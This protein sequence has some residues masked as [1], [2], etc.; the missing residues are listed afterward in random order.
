MHHAPSPLASTLSPEGYAPP[1]ASIWSHRCYHDPDDRHGTAKAHFDA[2]HT[3]QALDEPDPQG[4]TER[5][6]PLG[7]PYFCED[8]TGRILKEHPRDV[9][10][11][12]MYE[13]HKLLLQQGKYDLDPSLVVPAAGPEADGGAAEESVDTS[14]R[15]SEGL[16]RLPR[17]LH[18]RP[19]ATWQAR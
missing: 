5:L 17:P 12:R 19:S 13:E 14:A 11:R 18:K 7:N 2:S 1:P 10:Y 16:K 4:W 6:D 3:R 8:A 15:G 9:A